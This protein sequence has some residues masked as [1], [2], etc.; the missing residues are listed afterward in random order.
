M[1]WKIRNEKKERPFLSYEVY[2]E[3]PFKIFSKQKT[4]KFPSRS[5]FLQVFA[6]WIQA[7]EESLNEKKKTKKT[8]PSKM[9]LFYGQLGLMSNLKSSSHP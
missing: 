8:T 7:N 3:I 1:P 4:K 2:F 5:A 9:D 6:H